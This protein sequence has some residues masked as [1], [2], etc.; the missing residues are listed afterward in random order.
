MKQD[1]GSYIH[2][3]PHTTDFTALQASSERTEQAFAVGCARL[4]LSKIHADVTL[5]NVK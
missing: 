3:D 4:L 2:D 5:Q 1:K